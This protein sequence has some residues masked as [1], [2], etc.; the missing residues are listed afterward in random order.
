MLLADQDRLAEAELWL[1]RADQRGHA[2]AAHNLGVLLE[3]RGDIAG[4]AAAYSRADER[5]VADAAFQ[6]AMLLAAHDRLAEAEEALA[7]AEQRGHPEAAHN[8]AE[9]RERR[10]EIDG[11][12][13]IRKNADDERRTSRA[14]AVP[15]AID[16]RDR[17]RPMTRRDDF[18]ASVLGSGFPLHGCAPDGFAADGFAPAWCLGYAASFSRS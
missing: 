12:Q 15:A 3:E 8:L 14:E 6:L 2:T 9:L 11:P 1:A 4:A 16:D 7:R 18:A 13:S 5:G 10:R 17:A